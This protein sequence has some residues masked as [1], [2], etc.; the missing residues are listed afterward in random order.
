MEKAKSCRDCVYHWRDGSGYS[1]WTWMETNLRCA[2][3]VHPE[4]PKEEPYEDD[5]E[6]S[7]AYAEKCTHHDDCS[8][9]GEPTL[10]SP[11]GELSKGDKRAAALIRKISK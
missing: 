4:W 2:L 1:D 10:I 6:Q 3:A 7:F 11:D 8:Y 9:D 5:K